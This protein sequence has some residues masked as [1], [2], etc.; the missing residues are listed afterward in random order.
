LASDQTL[1][2]GKV[3]GLHGLR[4]A[5]KVV[6]FAE[7]PSSFAA[8]SE[9]CLRKGP[10]ARTYRL[11]KAQ[12][13]K[14]TLLLYLEGIDS[15]A[16]AEPLRGAK[17]MIDPTGLPPLEEGVYYWHELIGL[18]VFSMEGEP[19]GHIDSIIETGS[20]DVYVVK[21][22][23]DG[24]PEEILIPALESVVCSIN[25]AERSMYVDLPEGL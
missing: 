14:K 21:T 16:L 19:L 2:I 7:S 17:I 11:I 18:S 15:R 1:Q 12:Q 13:H 25:L 20:N 8:G 22:R 23:Q 10:A 9:L 4:G 5:L 3:V 6:S 24:K